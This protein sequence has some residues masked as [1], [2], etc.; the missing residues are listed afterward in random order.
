MKTKE[1]LESC[2]KIIKNL[3]QDNKNLEILF[4][5]MLEEYELMRGLKDKLRKTLLSKQI[6]ATKNL[7]INKTEAPIDGKIFFREARNRMTYEKFALFLTFIKKLNDKIICKEDAL[8]EIKSIFGNEN[9]DLYQSFCTLLL[10]K[11]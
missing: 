4:D 7:K 2:N 11:R 9:Y 6:K 10:R 8:V 5:D 1:E 3:E